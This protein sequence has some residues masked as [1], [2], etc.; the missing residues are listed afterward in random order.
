MGQRYSIEMMCII[1]ILDQQ[2]EQDVQQ[3]KS[4]I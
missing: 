2:E 4:R 3:N 1:K